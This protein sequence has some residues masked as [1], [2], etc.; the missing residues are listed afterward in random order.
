MANTYALS[1]WF[2]AR[3][4]ALIYCVAFVSVA[5]QARG[6]WGSRGILPISSYLEAVEMQTDL[7]RYWQLPSLF[8][9][10]SAD[11]FLTGAAWAGAVCAL[12][13]FAGFA[14]GWML[15]F[16]FLLYLSFVTA[17]QDFMSFQW[18]SLL[19]EAGFLALFAAPW[20]LRFEFF[21]AFEPH[22]TVR[23]M[24]YLLIFK[25][26]FLSGAVKILSG[27]PAWRDFSAMGYHYWT[28]PLPNPVSP[29]M[30]SLPAWYHKAETLLTFLIE[31]G[32]PFLIL[33]P[34]LRIWAGVGFVGLSAAIFFSGNYTFFNLLTMVLCLWLVP[35]QW[36]EPLVRSLP[37]KIEEA[38][39]SVFAHPMPSAALSV[40]ALLSLYWCTRFWIGERANAYL[41]PVMR[42]VQGF[43]ISN[44]YG[45]F[46]TMTKSR[47][48]IIFEG[49]FDAA[50]WK[51]YDFIY[52]P[53]NLYHTPP[54]VA[55]HQPRL[56][57]QM[58]FAALG[59]FRENY[60]FQNLM[61]RM[62]EN[63]PEVMAFFSV[64]PFEDK[65]PRF[66][67]AR[68]YNYTFASPSEIRNEGR[69]WHRELI[70]E[71]S[72]VIKRD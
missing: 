38:P 60:W 33:V 50:E 40:L 17:G 51:E 7:H 22:W 19:L 55:P 61:V 11:S 35:D 27:D 13:A 69:W 10:N 29:F 46:A 4:I 52:K 12:L 23:A 64:N 42:T 31:L 8:W 67:R 71:Y 20:A 1:A 62:L 72:P 45:L 30:H 36:W 28:Q 44:P 53:G 58:W 63:S 15:L 39:S 66:L 18:D 43:H 49:S 41:W 65:P 37:F 2:F 32:F 3:L 47:P 14:Q 68:L 48:E 57:W 25:L 54:V 59:S 34:R 16:C 21:T 6:L 5:V 56:D 26:M 9:F 24:F 70:G